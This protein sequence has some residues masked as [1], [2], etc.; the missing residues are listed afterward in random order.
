MPL[1]PDLDTAGLFS[2]HATLWK[3]A[4]QALYRSSLTIYTAFPTKIHTVGFPTIASSEAESVLLDFLAKL[5]TFLS[6]NVSTLNYTAL[7]STTGPVPT[8]ITTYL[9]DIYPTLIA[10]QQYKLVAEPFFADYAAKNGGR[11]PFVN[12]NPILRWNWGQRNISANATVEALARK[13]TFA[14]WWGGTVMR[15][16][17]RT[18]SDSLLLYPGTLARPRYRNEYRG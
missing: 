11:R 18:C 9:S 17:E 12:P 8:D 7:W 2:R 16:D 1:S 14:D 3:T 15:R 6:A 13:T 5:Q 10:Q 4:A